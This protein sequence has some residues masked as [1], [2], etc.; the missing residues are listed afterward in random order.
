MA[1]PKIT[2]PQLPTLGLFDLQTIGPDDVQADTLV[3]Y[4]TLT[5]ARLTGRDLYGLR[6]QDSEWTAVDLNDA[7]L[8][9]ARFAD[10][11]LVDLDLVQ[12][13]APHAVLR[14]VE[15]RQSRVGSVDLS[16]AE[17]RG[18]RLVGAKIGYLNLRGAKVVDVMF[19]S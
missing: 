7:S 13:S 4:S 17:L 9:D 18:V 12:L 15:I 8:K 16:A 1:A 5:G 2:P 11:R 14:N 19:E 3:D 6:V 10:S